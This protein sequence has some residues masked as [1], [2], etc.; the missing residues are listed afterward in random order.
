MSQVRP[1]SRRRIRGPGARLCVCR[2]MVGRPR[3]RVAVGGRAGGGGVGGGGKGCRTARD[4]I[5]FYYYSIK[6]CLNKLLFAKR[7]MKEYS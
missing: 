7:K 6:M 5:S 3:P 1:R 4:V 2:H